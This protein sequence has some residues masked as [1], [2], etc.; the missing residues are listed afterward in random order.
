M[1]EKK[2]PSITE[3]INGKRVLSLEE[4]ADYLAVSSWTIRK[5]IW[6]GRLPRLDIGVRKVLIDRQDLDFL[7]DRNKVREP[8]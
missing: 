3:L 1:K 5:L 6:D 4:A 2:K 8:F 7:I